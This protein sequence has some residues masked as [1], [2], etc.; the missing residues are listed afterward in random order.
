ME[1][2]VKMISRNAL[3]IVAA[4]VLIGVAVY[5]YRTM[6]GLEGF[7]TAANVPAAVSGDDIPYT[8]PGI[9]EEVRQKTC[10]TVGKYLTEYKK[11]KSEGAVI[12]GLD[13]AIE[14]F[15]NFSKQYNCQ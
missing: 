2:V 9:P 6:R 1:K 8:N 15:T 13:D 3:W 10:E 12:G 7:Q 5:L 14:K 11:H 4:A